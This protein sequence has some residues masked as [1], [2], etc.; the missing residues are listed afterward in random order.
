VL[1]VFLD[2]QKTVQRCRNDVLRIDTI[3]LSDINVIQ[4]PLFPQQYL[5]MSLHKKDNPTYRKLQHSSVQIE[6]LQ[7]S[8]HVQ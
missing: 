3:I 4:T 5:L 1:D 8:D 6:E 2:G 7:I